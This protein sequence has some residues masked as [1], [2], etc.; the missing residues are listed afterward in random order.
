MNINQHLINEKASKDLIKK[1]DKTIQQMSYKN[2]IL[3]K[4]CESL[5]NQY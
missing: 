2:Q 1:Q 3:K 5:N 4:Q